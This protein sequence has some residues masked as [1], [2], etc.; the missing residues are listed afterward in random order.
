MRP[1]LHISEPF[2]PSTVFTFVNTFVN[3]CTTSPRI[4]DFR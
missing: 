4:P 3:S 1:E 2:T